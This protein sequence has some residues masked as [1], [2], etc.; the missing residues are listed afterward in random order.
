MESA[1]DAGVVIKAVLRNGS[2]FENGVLKS[3]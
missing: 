3:K 1:L 2:A